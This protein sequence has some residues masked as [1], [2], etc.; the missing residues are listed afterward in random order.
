VSSAT[1]H[2]PFSFCMG[3]HKKPKVVLALSQGSLNH[4][5]CRYYHNRMVLE[6]DLL[7]HGRFEHCLPSRRELK[8]AEFIGRFSYQVILSSGGISKHPGCHK[9]HHKELVL[10]ARFSRHR[11]SRLPAVLQGPGCRIQSNRGA[12]SPSFCTMRCIVDP[13]KCSELLSISQ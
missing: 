5:F 8:S 11:S 10:R 9:E 1:R 12:S 6:E 2:L 7:E 13:Y 4:D 3:S